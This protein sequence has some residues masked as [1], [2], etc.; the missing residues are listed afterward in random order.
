ML[1]KRREEAQ[2]ALK[3]KKRSS[4]SGLTLDYTK[5]RDVLCLLTEECVSR[6]DLNEGMDVEY[7]TV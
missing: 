2:I 5:I 1:K 6:E 3:K 4:S 7:I